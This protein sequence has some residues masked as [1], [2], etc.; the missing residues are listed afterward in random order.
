DLP[1]NFLHDAIERGEAVLLLDGLD[2]VGAPEER[3]AMSDLVGAF[4]VLNPRLPVLVTTRIAGYD[5]APLSGQTYFVDKRPLIRTGVAEI[6]LASLSGE[7][8]SDS[9]HRLLLFS[10]LVLDKFD[11]AD[12]QAF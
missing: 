3:A 9:G 12:L 2:E 5:E 7:I 10:E 8:I 11:D 6:A 1:K 4:T